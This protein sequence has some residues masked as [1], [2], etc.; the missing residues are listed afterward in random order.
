M[1]AKNLLTPIDTD[2]WFEVLKQD[3]LGLYGNSATLIEDNILPLL[4]T[5]KFDE[6][7]SVVNHFDQQ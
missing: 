2:K 1:K 4:Q 7:F 6:L 3:K 5:E